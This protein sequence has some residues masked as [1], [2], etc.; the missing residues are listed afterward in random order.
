MDALV[1]KSEM[2]QQ[3]VN[4]TMVGEKFRFANLPLNCYNIQSSSERSLF[5]KCV[6]ITWKEFNTVADLGN[7]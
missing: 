4:Q 7:L 1:A 5:R 3:K 2:F 6:E